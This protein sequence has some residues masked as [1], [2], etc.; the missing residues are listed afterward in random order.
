MDPPDLDID[1]RLVLVR[2]IEASAL[3]EADLMVVNK[4]DA[5]KPV[6]DG[7]DDV[8]EVWV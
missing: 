8:G 7:F 5:L 3:Q 4:N 2:G 1:P 6:L